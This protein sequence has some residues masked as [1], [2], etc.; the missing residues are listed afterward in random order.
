MATVIQINI[1]SFPDKGT[2]WGSTLAEASL[3]FAKQNIN[4]PAVSTVGNGTIPADQRPYFWSV[5][6]SG[7]DIWLAFGKTPV[8]SAGNDYLVLAGTTRWFKG[9][10]GDKAA[11]LNVV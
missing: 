10:A 3:P 2:P 5:S 1:T 4:A 11:V 9:V 6:V 7:G 8:A